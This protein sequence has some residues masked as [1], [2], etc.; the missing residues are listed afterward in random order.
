MEN[1]V[2]ELETRLSFQ[3]DTIH[4]LNE[5]ITR[6]QNQIDLLQEQVDDLKKRVQ[7]VQTSNIK[8]ESEETPPPHY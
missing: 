7:T 1:R 6:Q 3:E 5:V 2:I 8:D 4:Q